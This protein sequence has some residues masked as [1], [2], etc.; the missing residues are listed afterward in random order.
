MSI[1]T[2]V[3]GVKY[4]EGAVALLLIKLASLSDG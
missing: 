2:T 1:T 3:D 4:R